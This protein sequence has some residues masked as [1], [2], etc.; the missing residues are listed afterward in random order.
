MS[1]GYTA[2]G[3][4]SPI[5]PIAGLG[6]DQVLSV[7]IVTPDGRFITADESQ[8]TDLFWAIRGGGGGK[9]LQPIIDIIP[10]YSSLGQQPGV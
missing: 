6:A 3:G 1:G 7:D 10:V 4:H 5:S 9:F 2:G 8:N